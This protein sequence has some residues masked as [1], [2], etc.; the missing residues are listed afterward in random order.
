MFL[1]QFQGRITQKAA[2]FPYTRVA[3]NMDKIQLI[4]LFRHN[5]RKF[6]NQFW[7]FMHSQNGTTDTSKN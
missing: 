1:I 7:A 4:K 3:P 2:E 5:Q 6:S